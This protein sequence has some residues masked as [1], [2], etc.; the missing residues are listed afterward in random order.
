MRDFGEEAADLG[1]GVFAGLEAAEE[2]ED[3][4]LVVEDG[5]VGLL[6]GAGAGGEWAGAAG[7]GEGGGVVA[8]RVVAVDEVVRVGCGR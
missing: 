7:G 3:E 5:G 1:V 4:F 6:G 8:G 2:F